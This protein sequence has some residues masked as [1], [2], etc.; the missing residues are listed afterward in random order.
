MYEHPGYDLLHAAKM[1]G[2]V[3]PDEWHT[4]LA[5]RTRQADSVRSSGANT[6]SDSSFAKW[7]GHIGT[8]R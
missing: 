6:R 1:D 7:I 8:S 2:I 5:A 4:D 3:R